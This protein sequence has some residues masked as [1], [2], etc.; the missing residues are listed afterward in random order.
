MVRHIVFWNLSEYAE[1]ADKKTNGN[2]I[3]TKLEDL[4]GKIDGIVKLEV[5][6]NYNENGFDLCLYSIFESNEALKKYQTH[7]LHIEIAQFVKKVTTQRAVTDCF[8]KD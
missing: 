5:D 2:I 4:V 3:K 7:P 8:I 6:F 1:N